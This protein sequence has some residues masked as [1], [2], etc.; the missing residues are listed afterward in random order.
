VAINHWAR[1]VA[2]HE[3][4]HP[5]ARHV[6]AD[7][8][9][10]EADPNRLVPGGRLHL[11]AASPECT[12]HSRARGG[13]PCSDQSRAS[14]M[15]VIHWATRLRVQDI[16]VEN[17]QE[18]EEWGPLLN[19]RTFFN[20]RWY[21]KDSPDPRRKGEA[22]RAWVN[23]LAAL[24]YK[25]EWRVLNAADYGEA[26]TRKR[27]FVRATLGTGIVWPVGTHVG[28]WRA[29]R[30]IIDWSL[31]NQSIF[32]RARPLAPKTLQ[33]IEAGLRKFGGEAFIAVLRGTQESQAGAWAKPLSEPLGTISAG[34]IH[35]ALCEPENTTSGQAFIVPMEH[36]GRGALRSTEQPLPT[37]TTAKAG[38]IGLCEPFVVNVAHDGADASRCRSVE[39]PL[40]T[41]PAGHRGGHAL[42]EPFVLSPSSGGVPRSVSQPIPTICTEARGMA[43]CEPFVTKYYGTGIA[44]PVS[45]PLDTVTAKGRFALVEP[46]RLDIRFR[47]LQPHE[48]ARAMGFDGYEFT[49]NKTEQVR[50]VGNAVSVR[51]AKAL[52][53]T[54]LRQYAA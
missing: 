46:G 34:G 6:C 9:S 35:A 33:R 48:L 41:I 47:M 31:P 30:E 5:W 54:I 13:K 2:T 28:K 12:H 49:G 27:L 32:N 38:A 36:S 18:F 25:V 15:H 42:C 19:E 4:N 24:G 8:A 16:L 37:I 52:A 7:L 26:T 50:Q 40:S 1:A 10:N 23:M 20:G 39:Q 29:A 14:A 45:A 11:L 44:K 3:R 53:R 22:F 43:L 17:V 51:Q 21:A